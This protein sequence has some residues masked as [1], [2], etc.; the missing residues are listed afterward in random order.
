MPTIKFRSKSKDNNR[1]SRS[2]LS[3]YIVQ[4]NA[5]RKQLRHAKAE[6]GSLNIAD[7]NS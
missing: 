2:G 6:I 4:C 7:L 5:N 3:S 1:L